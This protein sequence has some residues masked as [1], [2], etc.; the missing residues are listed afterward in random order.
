MEFK[1]YYQTLGVSRDADEKEIKKAYR[2]LARQYHPDVYSGPDADTKFKE[3]NEA[4]Q[5]LSDPE[6]REKYDRFGK[7]WERYQSATDAGATTG[8]DFAQWFTQSTG[9]P[10]GQRVHYNFRTSG[11][12]AGDFSDFFDLLF[13]SGGFGSAS[14]FG[15]PQPERGQDYEHPITLTLAEAFSGTTRTFDIQ[16][17]N[18]SRIEVTI[19]PGVREG[20]RVR[21]AGKGSPGR[22]GGAPG[23]VYL[24]V[25]LKQGPRFELDGN[26]LRT[27]VDVPLYTAILGGEV[28]L[29]TI[30]GKKIALTIEPETQNGR[31]IRLRGQGWPTGVRSQ[32]RGDLK[33]KVNVVL[34]TDLDEEERRMFREL[35]QHREMAATAA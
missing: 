25:H 35:A 30:T 4:Y 17:P 12:G 5:V 11:G 29:E 31:I 1:D 6:K 10:G 13:G 21:V 8:E 14:G 9:R 22:N 23:D 33:A 27:T 20:S 3:I 2:K 18:R 19:P 34:P 28:V 26:D 7:D 16:S 24:R 15:Q 32:R